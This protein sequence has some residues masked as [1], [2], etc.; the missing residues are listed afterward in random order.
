MEDSEPVEKEF[1]TLFKN[2]EFRIEST[3]ITAVDPVA[4]E[5]GLLIENARPGIWKWITTN[6]SRDYVDGGYEDH[7]L[8]AQIIAIHSDYYDQVS[9]DPNR[10]KV[11]DNVFRKLSREQPVERNHY[12]EDQVEGG[13]YVMKLGVGVDVAIAAFIDLKHFNNVA[14]LELSSKPLS[15]LGKSFKFSFC[16]EYQDHLSNLMEQLN[17]PSKMAVPYGIITSSGYGD[18]CYACLFKKSQEGDVIAVRM[19]FA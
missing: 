13:W 5:N 10:W 2:Q 17:Y 8:T 9:N 1:E 6:K 18:G 7:H 12:Y 3:T 15:L 19:I 4:S 11:A 16:S 14:S